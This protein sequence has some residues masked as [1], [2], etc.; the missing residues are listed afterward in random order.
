MILPFPARSRTWG[1]IGPALGSVVLILLA[2]GH[3]RT[4]QA[5]EELT[6]PELEGLYRSALAGHE[7]ALEALEKAEFDLAKEMIVAL[8][9]QANTTISSQA[10]QA[11]LDAYDAIRKAG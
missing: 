8:H 4:A 5:Q 6:V 11:A 10:R 3:P 9:A 2:L 1:R 7:Q